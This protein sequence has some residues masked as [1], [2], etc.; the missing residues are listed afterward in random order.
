[1]PAAARSTVDYARKYA[2]N[3]PS[4]R[5]ARGVRGARHREPARRL[6]AARTAHAPLAAGAGHGRERKIVLPRPLTARARAACRAPACWN[7]LAY[8]EF[9]RGLSR[10]TLEAYRVRPAAA[11]RLPAPRGV[12]APP[13]A[14]RPRAFLSELADGRPRA[15]AR[16]AGDAAAQGGVPAL[17]L[18][19]PAPRGRSRPRPDRRPARARARASACR[20]CSAAARSRACSP[21]PRAP[22]RPRCATARCSS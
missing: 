10:N 20:R 2:Q 7:F 17:V 12:D 19:P 13:P 16:R 1:M 6:R 8:L 18:P 9:E 5:S 15:P 11:R 3:R 21:R 14:R 22:S 4:R